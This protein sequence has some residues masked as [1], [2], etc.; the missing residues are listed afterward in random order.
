M[1]IPCP[2][3]PP[4]EF[5]SSQPFITFSVNAFQTQALLPGTV[6]LANNSFPNREHAFRLSG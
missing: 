3:F 1:H 4:D 2:T 6:Q 5:L